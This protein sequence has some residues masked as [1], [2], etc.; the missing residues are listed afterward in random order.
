MPFK[1]QKVEADNVV[2]KV[3][4]FTTKFHA[5]E[6][7]S[8]KVDVILAD[9]VVYFAIIVLPAVFHHFVSAK[10]LGYGDVADRRVKPN[11]ENF[12]FIA[13]KWHFDSPLDVAG[14]TARI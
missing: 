1:I 5:W 14:D 3:V 9:K 11:V 2:S 12:I 7:N 6:E 10:F 4:F 8:V 13:F